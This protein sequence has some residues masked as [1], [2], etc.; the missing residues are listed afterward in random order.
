[1]PR[2]HRL[3]AA[4]ALL[5]FAANA[6]AQKPPAEHAEDE[7]LLKAAGCPVDAPGLLEFFRK[8]T[9]GPKDQ[10]RAAALAGR[11]GDDRFEVREN[12]S[13]ELIKLGALARPYL[14][15]ALTNK[16]AEVRRRAHDCLE[17]IDGGPEPALVS[18][19]AR[20]LAGRSEAGSAA[21]VIAYM[22]WVPNEAVEEDVTLALMKVVE[23][24]KK[25]DAAL[26]EALKDKSA[27]RRGAAALA[28]GRSGGDAERKEVRKLLA[29]PETRVR[30]RAAQGLVAGRDKSGVPA[31]IELLRKG[32]AAPLAEDLL[33]RVAGDKAPKVALGDTD[34]SRRLCR[35]AWEKWWTNHGDKVSLASAEVDPLVYDAP[36]RA[37][38]AATRWTDALAK[39]DVAAVR[40][41]TEVP[42]LLVANQEFNADQ[43][44]AWAKGIPNGSLV[45]KAPRL[46]D[47]ASYLRHAPMQEKKRVEDVPVRSVFAVCFTLDENR[48]RPQP[49]YVVVRCK[50]GEAKVVAIGL[51]D[52]K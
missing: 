18:A 22:H 38:D 40:K 42:F 47:G 52:L 48:G 34:E 32:E 33:A 19:A 16:D 50:G 28:V 35:E 23:R 25:V 14:R 8:R 29:D 11:L 7:K 20:L 41:L 10:E 9:F 36:R 44:D 2:S 37:T 13:Q 4:A 12:A 5:L 1:M 15:D 46:V 26:V 39:G 6:P 21:V 45:F 30:L 24:E 43:L 3:L 49:V 31:L 17:T 51:G 27:V